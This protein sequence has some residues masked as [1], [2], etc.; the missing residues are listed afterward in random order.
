MIVDAVSGPSRD[1]A[2]DDA[3]A[4]IVDLARAAASGADHVMMVRPLAYDV[5]VLATW[6]VQPLDGAKCLQHLQRPEYRRATDPETSGAR[7]VDELA[8]GEVAIS[9]RNQLGQCAPRF[10]QAITST[11]ERLDNR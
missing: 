11:V 8:G 1:L 2:D 5:G 6:K 4:R 9:V 7:V 3:Q 10:G